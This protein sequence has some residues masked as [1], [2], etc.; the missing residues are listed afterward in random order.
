MKACCFKGLALHEK[1]Y[2]FVDRTW[3]VRHIVQSL[4]EPQLF[5]QKKIIISLIIKDTTNEM[6]NFI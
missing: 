5:T 1:Y 4:V 3:Q 6:Q 2:T